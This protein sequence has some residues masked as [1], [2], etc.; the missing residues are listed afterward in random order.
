[1]RLREGKVPPATLVVLAALA[2]LGFYVVETR[3][4]DVRSEWYAEKKRASEKT[5]LGQAAIKEARKRAGLSVHFEHDP[6]LTGLIGAD[7]QAGP[8]T[9][10]KGYL[11]A[12]QIATN[13]NLAAIV[14]TLLKEAKVGEGDVVAVGMTGSFPGANLATICAIEALK[15]R[16][17]VI[18]SVGSSTFGAN[19]AELTWLDMEKA[20]FDAG[21]IKTRSIAASVGGDKDRGV[22]LNKA[23][24]DQI[25]AAIRRNGVEKIEANTLVESIERRMELY[26]KAAK[27][28]K[29]RCYVNIG[30]GLASVGSSHVAQ[31]L[32]DTGLTEA[33]VPRNY[34]TEGVML[35]MLKSGKP[36]IHLMDFR[37]LAG[38][39]RHPM[40]PRQAE[41]GEVGEGPLFIS[42]RYNLVLV[43]VTLVVLLALVVVS[44]RLDLTHTFFRKPPPGM[45]AAP[46][47][48]PSGEPIL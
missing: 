42:R 7:D 2:A 8:L 30:G 1:M 17:I 9:T 48:P 11:R 22:G 23:A 39:P 47:A 27:G 21:V 41:P 25:D 37:K 12:K 26:E 10:D 45:P 4:V 36:V 35:K 34:P 15:A 14:V 32:I 20:L 24:I 44:V 29:I 40:P 5:K 6:M 38:D 33:W 13:P 3:Q 46:P 43:V 28:K 31:K 19:E 18:S 16:P